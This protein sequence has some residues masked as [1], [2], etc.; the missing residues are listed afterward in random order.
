MAAIVVVV[1]LILFVIGS[2]VYI[3][4]FRGKARWNDVSE[5]ARKGW[6]IFAVLNCLLYLFTVKRGACPIMDVVDF[7]EFADIQDNWEAIRD[8]A[9]QLYEFKH[10]ERTNNPESAAYYDLGFRTFCDSPGLSDSGGPDFL[11]R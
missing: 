7:P 9:V 10:F 11:R 4:R 1:L 6:P 5:Y 8:E 2:L 3:Y